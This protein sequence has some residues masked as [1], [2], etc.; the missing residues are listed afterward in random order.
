MFV[1]KL[2][3][4]AIVA[5]AII[6]PKPADTATV[7]FK[8]SCKHAL[9]VIASQSGKGGPGPICSLKSRKSCTI[10]YPNKTSINFSA[11]TGTKTLAEFTFN[12]GFD[13]LDW[14]DLSVVDGFDTS[15]RLLTPDK[16][17]LTCEKPNCPD[18]YDFSSDNSKTHACKSGGT[19]TL[20]FCP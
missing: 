9:K 17:V 1:S 20:I 15:M 5:I 14:Y 11:S 18:A 13:D 8:N 10:H 12:S 3:L 19:F 7:I 4:V 16:K 6:L 2:F